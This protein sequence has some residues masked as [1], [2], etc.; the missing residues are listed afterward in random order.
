[1]LVGTTIIIFENLSTMTR[2]ALKPWDS[3]SSPIRST[4]MCSHGPEGT[5]FGCSGFFGF[6]RCVFVLW[7][8]SQPSTYFRMSD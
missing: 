1:M 2:I 8:V 4:E 5:S 6:W 3:G 7:Q